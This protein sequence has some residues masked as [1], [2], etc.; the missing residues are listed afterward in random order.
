MGDEKF[1]DWFEEKFYDQSV[2]NRLARYAFSK[3]AWDHQQKRIDELEAKIEW[4]K[5]A[6]PALLIKTSTF[7]TLFFALRKVFLTAFSSP[8]SQQKCV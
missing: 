4:F 1:E 5:D 6:I 8:T 3:A 2:T 7:P